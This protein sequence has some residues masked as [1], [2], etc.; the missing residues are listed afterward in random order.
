MDKVSAVLDMFLSDRCYFK[1]VLV[2]DKPLKA[3]KSKTE[4]DI[5][6]S[7]Q[8]LLQ[9]KVNFFLRYSLIEYNVYQTIEDYLGRRPLFLE[10]S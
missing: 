6:L 2:F 9:V 4:Y 1:I 8:L 10:Y 3:V 7:E 5:F